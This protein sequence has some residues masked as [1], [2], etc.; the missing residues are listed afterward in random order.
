VLVITRDP[1]AYT[2]CIS[3]DFKVWSGVPLTGSFWL[4]TNIPVLFVGFLVSNKLYSEFKRSLGFWVGS[5][6]IISSVMFEANLRLVKEDNSFNMV[7]EVVCGSALYASGVFC[8]KVEG[9]RSS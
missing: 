7:R 8:L 2:Q 1:P 6:K 5:L 3:V 4:L 9:D